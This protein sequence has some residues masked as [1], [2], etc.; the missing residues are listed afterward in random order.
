MVGR[1]HLCA[2][3]SVRGGGE[4]RPA[5]DPNRQAPVNRSGHRSAVDEARE[6]LHRGAK[7]D[8]PK[9]EA[10]SAGI[11]PGPRASKSRKGVKRL[12]RRG[13]A[14]G[15]GGRPRKGDE[16]KTL[17][18]TRPWEAQG[19]SQRTWYR[20]QAEQNKSDK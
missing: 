18:A 6:G 1:S 17:R 3:V 20:R 2:P 11:A 9:L 4:S 16:A 13:P 12:G 14:P 5:D 10:E 7:S 8:D 19:I 15:S